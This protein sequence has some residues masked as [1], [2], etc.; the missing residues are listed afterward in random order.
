MN[1]TDLKIVIRESLASP[2]S[3]FITGASG[4]GK[5]DVIA[6]LAEDIS[7]ELNE[8]FE[9][10][11][12]RLSQFD[13]TDIRGVLYVN[14]K[15]GVANWSIPAIFPTDP[16]WSGFIFLDEITSAPQMVQAS[17]YQL[18]LN[19][20]IGEYALP[21]G[22]IIIA[23]GNRENDRGVVF[24]I[25]APLANR[26][27]HVNLEVDLKCWKQWAF[28]VGI[29][30]SIIGYLSFAESNLH[31]FKADSTEKAWPSPRTWSFVDGLLKYDIDDRLK[32][33]LICG[34][35]GIGAGQ[36]FWNYREL[37]KT[38]FDLEDILTKPLELDING[39]NDV[40]V[41][42][43]I[44]ASIISRFSKSK[45]SKTELT[46]ILIFMNKMP[47]RYKEVKLAM[48]MELLDN[49]FQIVGSTVTTV[50]EQFQ[51]LFESIKDIL[52][53]HNDSLPV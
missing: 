9:L 2:V 20:K 12:I 5:S 29:D 37:V 13:S 10:V 32:Q 18:I 33:E 44:T 30:P 7:T 21:E 46:N 4:I 25:V 24:K 19:R 49:K 42:Y 40:S 26:F 15:T 41:Y 8:P 34:A 16:D 50:K 48:Y 53:N 28:S 14:P 3:L 35:V 38:T 27:I 23:A 11:D 1:I 17:V 36:D 52:P 45:P 43:N 31:N 6:Q 51:I 22:A 47:D 39:I